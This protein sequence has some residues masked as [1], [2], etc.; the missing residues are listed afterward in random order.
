MITVA[1]QKF[2]TN[3][4]M[5]R[6]KV[7]KLRIKWS[8]STEK[9]PDIWVEKGRVPVI[10]V[11][12]EWSK[13]KVHERRKRL[14]HEALHITGLEHGKIGGLEYSTDPSKDSYSKKVYQELIG[15]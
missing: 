15:R 7:K 13:Q 9:W 4:L 2:I 6:F 10:T 3:I 12:H 5:P 8:V 1:D 11:T 14:V